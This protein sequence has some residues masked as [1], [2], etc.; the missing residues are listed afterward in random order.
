WQAWKPE[1][2]ERART[3][4][5]LILIGVSAS[6]CHWCHVMD[7]R[8]YGAPE[9]QT[10]LAANFVAVR[11]DADARPDLATRYAR[12]GWPATIVLTPEAEEVAGWRGYQSVE[13]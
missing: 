10:L 1:T 9:V 5:K 7:E 13:K 3:S 6:W 4:G 11:V 8:T 12:F 2:F